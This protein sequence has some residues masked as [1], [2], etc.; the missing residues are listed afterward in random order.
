V[1][2]RARLAGLERLLVPGYDVAS[3]RAAVALAEAEPD[4]DAAVGVHPHHAAATDEAGWGELAALAGRVDV[5]AVGEI[6]L[7]FHRNLSPPDVQRAGFARQLA[8]AADL[9]LPVIV[10][11]RDAHDE[12]RSALLAWRGRS[13]HA[14]RGVLHAFSGDLAMAQELTAAGFV[15]SFALPLAF[16]SA[17]GPRA[18][19]AAIPEDRML[20]ET[21]APWLAPGG[22]GMRNEP[23]TTLRVAA[24]LA[25]LRGITPESVAAATRSTYR[26]LTGR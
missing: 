17:A 21:D 1:L 23:T 5:V 3:S 11:D 25:R 18:A 6:G 22:A 15:V 19:A 26:A 9:D 7:D 20:V 4:L 14:V 13:R 12:I 16:R 24:E 2:A 8:L 10:H